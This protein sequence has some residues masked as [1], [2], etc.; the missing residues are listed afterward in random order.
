MLRR[1]RIGPSSKSFFTCARP[2][3]TGDAASKYA[4]VPDSK[5]HRWIMGLPGPNTAI[6]SLLGCKPDGTSEFSF[7][8]F[9][10]GFDRSSDRPDALSFHEWLTYWHG[11]Q[12]IVLC[13]HP[14]CDFKPIPPEVLDAVASDVD[15]LLSE[16]RTVVLIDSG[17]Q[18]RTM[19]VCNHMHAVE[20]SSQL[21]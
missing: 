1:W 7:Y 3:R 18:T 10:G 2:G 4:L 15:K 20:N 19:V 14:T 6:V 8:S 5:V 12:R 11:D 17:G 9:Y 16:G 13:E 21:P